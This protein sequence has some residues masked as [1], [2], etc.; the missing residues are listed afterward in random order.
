MNV[1]MEPSADIRQLA[2]ALRQMFIALT[3][4]GFEDRQ[5]LV[6]IG[7]VLSSARESDL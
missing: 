1:P 4:V 3:D 5:A 2:G 7:Q 6:I